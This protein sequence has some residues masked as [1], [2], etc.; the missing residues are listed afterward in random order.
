M[1]G[2]LCGERLHFGRALY[3]NNHDGTFTDIAIEAGWPIRRM[4]KPQAGMGVST[5]DYDGDGNFDIVKTNFAGDTSSLYRN[6]GNNVFEDTTF[7]A[8]LGRNTRFLGWGA[9]FLDY[10]NDT[11]PDILLTM[12]MCIRRWRRRRSNTATASARCCIAIWATASL[13]MYRRTRV[14]DSEKVQRARLRD[15]RF[16]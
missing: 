13:T 11:W 3:R 8:G 16:R 4:A 15:G 9:M 14:R 12:D 10:D 7:Q 2:Y 6:L 1:A 5:A